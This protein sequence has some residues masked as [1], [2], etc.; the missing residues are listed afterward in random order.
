MSLVLIVRI[1][2]NPNAD[3]DCDQHAASTGKINARG[4]DVTKIRYGHGWAK[5]E[6]EGGR[7]H[8]PSSGSFP[9]RG[10]C[11]ASDAEE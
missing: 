10:N 4:S 9:W 1:S 11:G 8:Q 6:R 2:T 3:Q 5:N 7:Y